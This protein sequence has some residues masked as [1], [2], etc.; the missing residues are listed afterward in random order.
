MKPVR[1]VLLSPS[2]NLTALVTGTWDAADEPAITRR[3]LQV[4]EQ[5]A[6]LEKPTQAGALA[7]V[8]LMGGEFCGNAAMAAA[9]W[10][11]RDRLREGTEETVPLE[12]SGAQGVLSCRIR[13]LAED[14]EGTVPMPQVLSVWD[15]TRFGVPLTAVRMEGILHLVR[16]SDKPLEKE[17]AENL[18]KTIAAQVPDAAVGLLDRNAGTGAIR[19]L[20]FVRG[21]GSLVWETACG[22]GTAAIGA[23]EAMRQG[24][25]TETAVP[26]PGGIIRTSAVFREDQ[27][28]SV[29]ITGIVKILS[30]SDL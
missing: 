21:S 10:L 16:E 11:I 3:L 19:P 5:V 6:Y 8:R 20:V 23:L 2:G 29:S 30:E 9:G 26:Q 15:K 13:G 4:S 25:T 7:R 12:V 27:F 24:K 22:S 1:Y 14:F 18:L 28:P 17:A